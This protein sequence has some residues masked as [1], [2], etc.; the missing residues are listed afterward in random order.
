MNQP[1]TKYE[2]S[3]EQSELQHTN[4]WFG[5][6]L[7]QEN[8]VLQPGDRTLM[9]AAI[10]GN[11]SGHEHEPEHSYTVQNESG[12]EHEHVLMMFR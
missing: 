5:V 3:T 7:C 9:V 6:E 4:H 12:H 2:Q 11:E 8:I 10:H 1:N